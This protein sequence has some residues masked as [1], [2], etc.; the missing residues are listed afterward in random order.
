[1]KT[2]L[3]FAP[4]FQLFPSLTAEV[5]VRYDHNTFPQESIVSP[6]LNLSWTPLAGTTVRGAWGKYAQSEALFGLH[7][8]DGDTTFARAER[9]EQ[10]I[11]GVEHAFPFGMS[12]RI[13]AYDKR[14]THAR[15]DYTNASGDIRLF[16]ELSWDRL[17]ID[18][19]AGRDRG[20]ELQLSRAGG[21]QVDWS[22]GYALASS[23]DTVGGRAVPRS[24]DQ[25]H[26][27]HLDWS[28]HPV[29]NAWRLSVGGVWHSGWPYTPTKFLVDTIVNGSKT[30]LNYNPTPGALNSERLPAYQRVDARFTRYVNTRSGRWS[31]FGEV[32]NLF[33][34]VN[35]RGLTKNASVIGPRVSI[36]T[37]EV[38][39]WPRL[40]IAGLT[41]E[42]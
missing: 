21:E 1:M 35:I 31:V 22:V 18:R 12:G 33:D 25:K 39:Q 23:V 20:V 42:F 41:W 15:A 34:T 16:P 11:L 28:F 9:A 26:A 5:G 30:L 32:Y 27:V 37:V 8:Q 19:T 7:A 3:Y 14:R 24:F 38:T 10:R 17:R 4:R 2:A 36:R 13:E 29:S 6:R 40:P